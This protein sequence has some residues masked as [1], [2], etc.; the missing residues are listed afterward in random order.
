MTAS[1]SYFIWITKSNILHILLYM[2][3]PSII[4]EIK[5]QKYSP[6]PPQPSPPSPIIIA[7]LISFGQG[8]LLDQNDASKYAAKD[9]KEVNSVKLL[10]SHGSRTRSQ[11][12]LW[13]SI[14]I[15]AGLTNM[16]AYDQELH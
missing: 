6:P 13:T 4:F 3:K 11:G 16:I 14:S 1:T 15:Y 5:Y 8:L 12:K 7:W 9:L 2:Y 10:K